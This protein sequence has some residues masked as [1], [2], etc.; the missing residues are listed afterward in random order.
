MTAKPLFDIMRSI[1]GELLNNEDYC[2]PYKIGEHERRAFFGA[3]ARVST[4]YFNLSE[5]RNDLVHGTWFVGLQMP[6]QNPEEFALYRR[7]VT[8]NGI[9]RSEN[10]PKT[11]SELLELS[12]RCQG[13]SNWI[14]IIGRCLDEDEARLDILQCFKHDGSEWICTVP[15]PYKLPSKLGRNW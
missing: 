6:E 14:E 12:Y 2:K 9:A 10:L 3:I 7:K 5:I 13:A 4:E 11:A 1:I 8:K 15:S